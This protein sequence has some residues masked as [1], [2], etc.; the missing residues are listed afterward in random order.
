VGLFDNGRSRNLARI[1][2][3]GF[4]NPAGLVAV[5]GNMFKDTVNAGKFGSPQRPG[6]DGVGTIVPGALESSNVDLSVEFVDLIITQ[7]GFQ[8]QSR[9]ITTADQVLQ[10]VLSLKR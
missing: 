10:E 4:V 8:A 9:T 6:F 1:A 3:Q 7:R 5:G 2:L